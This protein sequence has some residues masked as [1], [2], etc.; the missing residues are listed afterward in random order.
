MYVAKRLNQ[1]FCSPECQ[2]VWQQSNTGY[3]NPKFRGGYVICEQCGKR[4]LVGEYKLKAGQHRFCS[5]ECR[6]KWYA[7]TWSQTPEW[8]EESRIRAVN[9]LKKNPITTQTK[10]QVAVNAMLDALGITYRNEEPFKYYSVDNYLPDNNLIIEVMG[11]FW[12]A[13]PL[14][15]PTVHS[16][17]QRQT[18]SRDKAKHTYI[19]NKHHIEILYLWETD[20]LKRP[21]LCSALI[22]FYVDNNGGITNYHSFNYEMSDRGVCL[23]KILIAPH[24]EDSEKVAC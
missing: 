8:R 21:E 18:I 23:R 5:A 22:Q 12:H 9:L 2:R 1:R 13:S 3:D 7:E 16:E 20:I 17:R 19:L 4:F 10:P 11:D 6:R 15:Y 14:V 24:Q